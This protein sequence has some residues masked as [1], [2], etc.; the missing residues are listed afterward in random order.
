MRRKSMSF[1][2][3]VHFDTIHL[4]IFHETESLLVTSDES[5][6][7][8]GDTHNILEEFME[9]SLDFEGAL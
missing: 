6:N 2:H 5:C 9:Q 1:I 7:A 3:A 4:Q 8:G